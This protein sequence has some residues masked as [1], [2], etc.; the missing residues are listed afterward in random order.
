MWK[1]DNREMESDISNSAEINIL[2]LLG[3]GYIKC[4][5]FYGDKGGSYIWNKKNKQS[6][7]G[8]RLYEYW[9]VPIFWAWQVTIWEKFLVK[10]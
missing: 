10:E 4:V 8:K 9:F 3:D 2:L 6:A 7:I 5:C 1:S